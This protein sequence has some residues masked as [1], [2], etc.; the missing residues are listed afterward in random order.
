MRTLIRLGLI[1]LLAGCLV[2]TPALADNADDDDSSREDNPQAYHFYD[3]IDMVSKLKLKYG[4]KP[5]FFAKLVYPQLESVDDN[6][7]VTGFNDL[8]TKFIQ[9]ILMQFREQIA[10]HKSLQQPA[11]NKK[12]KN[13]LYVD[14]DTSAI[15]SG[16]HHIIS[17]RFSMQGMFAGMAHPFHFHRVLNYDLDIG[18][19]IALEDLFIPDS[20]YLSVLADYCNRILTRR[21][22]YQDMIARGTAPTPDNYQNWN[23]K[24]TGLL[25]TFDEYRVA[26][27]VYGP[28][29]VLVPYSALKSVI[30]RDS[31][32]AS[33]AKHPGR[34]ARNRLLTGGF[35]DEA[36][37]TQHGVLN[38]VLST[39]HDLFSRLP[40][41]F[42][43]RAYD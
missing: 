26:P 32:I 1:T 19:T 27:Y 28:Q 34:C 43:Q 10:Q 14:Y 13:S 20:D 11:R 3:D 30:E 35:I 38:P 37:N 39:L 21:L 24:P 29:T 8:S 5:T 23:I 2:F 7:G 18:D 41:A 9:D 33:C 25:I 15:I 16:D 17:V 4:S 31:V 22:S 6:D 12:K 42:N 40:F 36:V